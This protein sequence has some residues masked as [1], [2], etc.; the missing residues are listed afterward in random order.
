MNAP[1]RAKDDQT[2]CVGGISKIA[3]YGDGLVCIP[4]GAEHSTMPTQ[5]VQ[6]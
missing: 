5:F 1:D 3:V 4:V 2:N 6:I